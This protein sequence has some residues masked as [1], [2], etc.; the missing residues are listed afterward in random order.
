MCRWIVFEQHLSQALSMEL[1]VRLQ[2][3]DHVVSPLVFRME[4]RRI[5]QLTMAIIFHKGNEYF[6]ICALDVGIAR[7]RNDFQG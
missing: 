6:Q 4:Q 1:D 7:I 3:L 2:A 5:E